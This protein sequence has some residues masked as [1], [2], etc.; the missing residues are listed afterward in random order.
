MVL[1]GWYLDAEDRST[2]HTQDFVDEGAPF[3][4][5]GAQDLLPTIN[6]LLA[7]GHWA[8]VAA[9]K[10]WHVSLLQACESLLQACGGLEV[11]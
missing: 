10:D 6:A 5:P 8:T 7:A 4:V 11:C 9:S 2:P 1:L 3:C